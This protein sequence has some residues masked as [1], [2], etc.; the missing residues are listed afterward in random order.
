M[1]NREA[2][3]RLISDA[4]A[5]AAKTSGGINAEFDGQFVIDWRDGLPDFVAA[6]DSLALVVPRSDIPTEY[7]CRYSDEDLANLTE[8]RDAAIEWARERRDWQREAMNQLTAEAVERPALPWSV[9]PLQV[10]TPCSDCGLPYGRQS[11]CRTCKGVPAESQD[12]A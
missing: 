1:D 4:V 3:E 6:L 12:D 2:L 9:I 10:V 5:L 8:T 11:D 7:G